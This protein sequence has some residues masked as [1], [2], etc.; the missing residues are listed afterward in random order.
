MSAFPVRFSYVRHKDSCQILNILPTTSVEIYLQSDGIVLKE[1]VVQHP[2]TRRRLE[3]F[4]DRVRL[5]DGRHRIADTVKVATGKVIKRSHQ[6][7]VAKV[8]T[9]IGVGGTENIHQGS[10]KFLISRPGFDFLRRRRH[11]RVARDLA[12]VTVAILSDGT[13]RAV[14]TKQFKIRFLNELHF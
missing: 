8:I 4:K 2:V 7:G 12:P 1:Q 9:T 10:E 5:T 3:E 6:A 14:D 11:D 13:T